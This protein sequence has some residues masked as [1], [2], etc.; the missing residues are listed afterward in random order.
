M[1]QRFRREVPLSLGLAVL[2][3]IAGVHCD[4]GLTGDPTNPSAP[5]SWYSSTDRPLKWA[6]VPEGL[7]VMGSEERED[8]RPRPRVTLSAFRMSATEVTAGQYA[9]CVAEGACSWPG[10]GSDRCNTDDSGVKPGREGHPMNCVTWAE[11]RRFAEW[12]GGRLPSEAEWEYAARGGEPTRDPSLQ[13]HKGPVPDTDWNGDRTYPVAE[14]DANAFGL[15]DMN[16]NVWEWV[17]DDWHASLE[18]APED[19][20]AWVDEPRASSRVIPVGAGRP[21]WDRARLPDRSGHSPDLRRFD[22]G[23]RVALAAHGASEAATESP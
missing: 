15:Y 20:S 5:D 12:K 8:E 4:G 10:G 21:S 6:T 2:L 13:K 3:S 18:G 9:G 17:E 1:L 14:G 11:A 16:G 22:Q 7:L 23:F 19:G